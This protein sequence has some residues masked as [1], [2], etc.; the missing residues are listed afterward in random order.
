MRSKIVIARP[1]GEDKTPAR[2]VG[3]RPLHAPGSLALVT[4]GD[5]RPLGAMKP[6]LY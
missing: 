1:G 6:G 4:G 5:T 2:A 3:Q